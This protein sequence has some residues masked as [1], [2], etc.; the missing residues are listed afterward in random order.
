VVVQGERARGGGEDARRGRG[1]EDV[2]CRR[3]VVG[4]IVVLVLLLL[5]LFV[6]V[7]LSLSVGLMWCE[8]A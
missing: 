2:G 5:L 3:C 8:R 7:F 1:R 6:F 4:M